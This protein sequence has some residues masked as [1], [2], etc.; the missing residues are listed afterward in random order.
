MIKET[1]FGER[2]SRYQYY[3]DGQVKATENAAGHRTELHRDAAGAIVKVEYDDGSRVTCEYDIRGYL[4]KADNGDCPVEHEY[5]AVGRRITE[6]QGA[7]VI[8]SAYD[9]NGNRVRRY[10]SPLCSWRR[11]HQSSV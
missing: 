9:A 1:D 3:K 4:I 5:D 11:S 10:S 2:V 7:Y 6:K 8:T